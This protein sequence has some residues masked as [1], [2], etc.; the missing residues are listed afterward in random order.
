MKKHF[1]ALIACLSIA[2]VN[3]E[4]FLVESIAI[5]NIHLSDIK[6]GS[7]TFS[8]WH[9]NIVSVTTK[10]ESPLFPVKGILTNTCIGT[11]KVVNGSALSEGDCVFKDSSGDSFAL[12]LTRDGVA[13]GA[14]TLGKASINGLSGKFVGM[15][16]KCTYEPVGL[17]TAE[18]VQNVPF[19]TCQ[20]QI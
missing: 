20:Y 5:G 4:S 10:S 13:G 15:T 1:V 14:A 11:S 7:D 9:I 8:S 19:F 12:H 6:S 2:G 17:K 16:G 3:A 18:G